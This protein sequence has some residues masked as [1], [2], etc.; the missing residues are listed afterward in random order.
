MRSLK[1]QVVYAKGVRTFSVVNVREPPALSRVCEKLETLAKNELGI[2]AIQSPRSE[3][4]QNAATAAEVGRTKWEE[5]DVEYGNICA[6]IRAYREALVFLDTVEPKPPE[7]DGYVAAL[8]KAEQEL[9]VRYR[10]Q[11]FKADRALNMSDWPT[12]SVELQILC[13]IVPDRDDDR[14]IEAMDKLN[15]VERRMK[16]GR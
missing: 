10:E 5:R 7:Y 6:S 9:D 13:Q 12:A 1:L 4:V 3:L 15:D 16:G 11:R 8:A 14:N 2:W